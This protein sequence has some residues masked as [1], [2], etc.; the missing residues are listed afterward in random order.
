MDT[1][2][3]LMTFWLLVVFSGGWLI[4]A[5]V[6]WAKMPAKVAGILFA[7]TLA[8]LACSLNTPDCQTWSCESP[9]ATMTAPQYLL[10]KQKCDRRARR[11]SDVQKAVERKIDEATP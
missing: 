8:I 3:P 4:F 7:V 6:Y 2:F 9:P 10:N 5:G 11:K 1:M